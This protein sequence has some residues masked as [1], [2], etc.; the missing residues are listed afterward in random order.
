MEADCVSNISKCWGYSF[1]WSRYKIIQYQK[2][3]IYFGRMCSAS[4][5][6][7]GIKLNLNRQQKCYPNLF[8]SNSLQINKN[9]I[10]YTNWMQKGVKCIGNLFDD[11]EHFH[12]YQEFT[13]KYNTQLNSLTVG[14][15][16]TVKKYLLRGM[17]IG[18]S[19][20]RSISRCRKKD[21]INAPIALSAFRDKN[22]DVVF[23]PFPNTFSRL[24]DTTFFSFRPVVPADNTPCQF[25]SQGTAVSRMIFDAYHCCM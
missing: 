8:F 21:D 2:T 3:V 17:Q 18:F 15:M 24:D 5:N 10:Y 1:I 25:W 19:I 7:L 4:T 16:Q 20:S 13:R 14:C 11:R 22:P 9:Y 23:F 12:T 6:N